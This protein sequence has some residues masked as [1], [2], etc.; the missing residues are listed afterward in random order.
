VDFADGL[1]LAIVAL[2][3]LL[4]ER[5]LD[6]WKAELRTLEA[7][8]YTGDE[9]L[10]GI[11]KVCIDGLRDGGKEIFLDIACFF[12][13]DDKKRAERIFESCGYN[14]GVNLNILLEKSLVTIV[15]GKLWMHDL[16]QETGQKM[17]IGQSKLLGERSRLWHHKEAISVLKQD[18]ASY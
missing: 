9:K 7:N 8:N 15:G 14:P 5:T 4:L 1:P 11:L 2:G 18:K 16:L 13:G 17:V 12:K 3:S 10:F 6:E